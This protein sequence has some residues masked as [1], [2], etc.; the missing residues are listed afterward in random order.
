MPLPLPSSLQQ[1]HL[2]RVKNYYYQQPP[3]TKVIH[4]IMELHSG[5]S[6]AHYVQRDF[7]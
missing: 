2:Q 5:F 6:P 1:Q 3:E 4:H 7:V